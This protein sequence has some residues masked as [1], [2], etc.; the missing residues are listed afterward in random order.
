MTGT[1]GPNVSSRAIAIAGVTPSSTVGSANSAVRNPAAR[2]PPQHN[3][4]PSASAPATC[5]SNLAAVGSLFSGPMVVA[6]S[7]GSPS[8]IWSLVAATTRSTNSA[9]TAACTRNRSPAVQLWPAHRY[10]AS[11][12][13]SVA[14]PRS[15]SSR[16]TMGPLPPSSRSC[17][18]PAARAATLAPVA[19]EP[20]N[21]TA[22]TPGWPATA[23]PTTGPGPGRKLNT[24]AGTPAP[25]MISASSAQHA[26]VVGAGTQTTVLPAAM[27]GANSSAPIVYGQFHGLMTPTTPSGTRRVSTRRD[28]EVDG[29]VPPAIRVASS[30]AIRKYSDSSLTSSRASASNGLP[31]SSVSARARSSAWPSIAAATAR[32]QAARSKADSA[33]QPGA[34]APAA[35]TASSTSAVLATATEAN[36]SPVAGLN[37][38]TLPARPSRQAPPT[39][40][41]YS[42]T[43]DP[44]LPQA[45][46]QSRPSES[47]V[48]GRIRNSGPEMDSAATHVPA[49]S[50]TGAATATSPSSSSATALA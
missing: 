10:A 44:L 6:G 26:E 42:C 25:V 43:T 34:A 18:L 15:A 38:G 8:L 35:A 39:Q 36:S 48:A 45:L 4:A 46:A 31:W 3:P 11:S 16:I 5:R 21:P 2:P 49:G 23:S 12:A 19:T 28:G 20:M 13:A 9:R 17:V 37:A 30:A 1:T 50:K 41:R 22:R 7:S 32:Q 27:A 29:G 14:R 33:A 47:R 40:I 24:P